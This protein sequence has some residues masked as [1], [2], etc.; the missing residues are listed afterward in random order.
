M[1]S[2]LPEKLQLPF[3]EW[4]RIKEE[5]ERIHSP[6]LAVRPVSFDTH[7]LDLLLAADH[8]GQGR[9]SE[10]AIHGAAKKRFQ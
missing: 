5:R 10:N 3:L 8:D 6:V 7:E 2:R 9:H 4:L 1:T